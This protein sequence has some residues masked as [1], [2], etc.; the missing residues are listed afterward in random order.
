MICN[1]G[2]IDCSCF[3]IDLAG[4]T[5]V[6]AHSLHGIPHVVTA[7]LHII[8]GKNYFKGVSFISKFLYYYK[9]GYFIPVRLA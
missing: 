4:S 5:N 7:T 3:K 9:G 8:M 1:L 6:L 2:Y